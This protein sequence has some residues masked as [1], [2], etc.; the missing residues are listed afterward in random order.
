MKI[1]LGDQSPWCGGLTRLAVLREAAYEPLYLFHDTDTPWRVG[2]RKPAICRGWVDYWSLATRHPWSPEIPGF[3]LPALLGTLH[4]PR[5]LSFLSGPPTWETIYSMRRDQTVIRLTLDILREEWDW[6]TRLAEMAGRTVPSFPFSRA[7]PVEV[8]EIVREFAEGQ[9][10]SSVLEF[11]RD[12]PT[13]LR[14]CLPPEWFWYLD[15]TGC[16]YRH[17]ELNCRGLSRDACTL[18]PKGPALMLEDLARGVLPACTGMAY[19]DEVVKLR[20]QYIPGLAVRVLFVKFD[21]CSASMPLNLLAEA[22]TSRK[23]ERAAARGEE[24][25][26]FSFDY[27]PLEEYWRG[28]PTSISHLLLGGELNPFFELKVL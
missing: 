8:G 10:T 27:A 14:N 11:F 3:S 1:E 13:E 25:V 19:L 22:F 21:W 18:V 9:M 12:H 17:S 7:L 16:K 15:S 5:G 26:S 2:G 20:D 24:F 6:A 4:A 28:R 23:R